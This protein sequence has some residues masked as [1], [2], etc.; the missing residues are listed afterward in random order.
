M[1]GLS[2]NIENALLLHD[3]KSIGR[4]S[5]QIT[6][7]KFNNLASKIEKATSSILLMAEVHNIGFLG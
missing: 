4:K 5:R 2:K 6:P 7:P 3:D 1:K